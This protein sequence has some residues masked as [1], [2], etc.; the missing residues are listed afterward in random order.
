MAFR[1]SNRATAAEGS[2]GLAVAASLSGSGGTVKPL[3]GMKF[4]GSGPDPLALE[5]SCLKVQSS[6]AAS[7]R[8]LRNFSSLHPVEREPLVT[9]RRSIMRLGGLLG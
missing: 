7:Q 5:E 8:C 4:V 3:P 9:G 6:L 1:A 2:S